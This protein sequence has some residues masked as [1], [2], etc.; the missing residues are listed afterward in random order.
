MKRS[1]P[2][3]VNSAWPPLARSQTA[4][5]SRVSGFGAKV[6]YECGSSYEGGTIPM[7][8]SARS[9]ASDQYM[10]FHS[11]V[12]Q[13]FCQM[14][15]SQSSHGVVKAKHCTCLGN[16]CKPEAE[17]CFAD[18]RHHETD[19]LT[20]G[21]TPVQAAPDNSTL[22]KAQ[23][24][25][26]LLQLYAAGFTLNPHADQKMSH[27]T[28]QKMDHI[29]SSTIFDKPSAS[30]EVQVA[31]PIVEVEGKL[32]KNTAEEIHDLTVSNERRLDWNNQDERKKVRW[33]WQRKNSSD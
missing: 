30:S 32:D 28:E 16:P 21:G 23:E 18:H 15:L 3:G 22:R 24:E 25:K 11:C 14:H 12:V 10:G 20:D 17:C 4:S 6:E 7:P 9:T 33:P 8:L 26:M 19:V 13:P 31:T 1:M 5:A 29:R 27:I 2:V